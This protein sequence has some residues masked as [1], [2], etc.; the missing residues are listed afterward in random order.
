[1]WKACIVLAT[2]TMSSVPAMA[3]TFEGAARVKDGDTHGRRQTRDPAVGR[4]CD[5]YTRPIG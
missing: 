3:Q 4:R 2:A 5:R 1:M